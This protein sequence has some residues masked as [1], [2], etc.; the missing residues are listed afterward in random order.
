MER[1]L[2]RAIVIREPGGPE[3]LVP[4]DL[5]APEPPASFVRVA[6]RYAGVNRADLLQRA[7][8]YPAPPGVPADIPGLEYSGVVDAVGEGVTRFAPGDRVCGLVG[9]GAY[10]ERLVAHEGEIARVPAA[11]DDR[12]AGAVPEVF[13]TAYDALLIRA[14]LAP[15]EAVL[16]HAAGSGVGTAA[17]QLAK[18]LGCFVI[19]T[20]RTEDK[21]ARCKELG[22]DVTLAVK[23]ASFADA[24]R[25]AT[26]GRGADVVLEL[27]GGSYVAEDVRAAAALGR[28]VVVGLT[29]GARADVD[30]RLLLMKRLTITGTV[31]RSRPLAEKIRSAEVLERHVLPLVAAGRVRPVID[32]VLSLVEAPAAHA[33]VASNASFGKV[34]LEVASPA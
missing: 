26:G 11:I 1:R 12:T 18:A 2:M 25:D 24:V 31:L 16:I 14:G 15:G 4:R 9:G 5:P 19:A 23:D 21:L 33:Y 3:V 17:I 7:G 27:A 29:A 34:L 10:A 8:M 13:V 32:R 30:L 28:I 22:A 20:S 6:V